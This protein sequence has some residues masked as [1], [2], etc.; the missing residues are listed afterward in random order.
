MVSIL[1]LPF[2]YGRHCCHQRTVI[3]ENI[4]ENSSSSWACICSSSQKASGISWTVSRMNSVPT[5]EYW[6]FS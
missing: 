4:P 3:I 6:K 1:G 5:F 2:L